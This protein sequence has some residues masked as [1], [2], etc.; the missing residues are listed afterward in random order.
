MAEINKN[1][2]RTLHATILS[3]CIL[4]TWP[5]FSFSPA[6][7]DLDFCSSSSCRLENFFF[8]A[9]RLR[10]SPNHCTQ[11]TPKKKAQPITITGKSA[12]RRSGGFRRCLQPRVPRVTPGF[13]AGFRFQ[14]SVWREKWKERLE[15]IKGGKLGKKCEHRSRSCRSDGNPCQKLFAPNGRLYYGRITSTVYYMGT[16]TTT[17]V[18]RAP[19]NL[20]VWTWGRIAITSVPERPVTLLQ[21]IRISIIIKYSLNRLLTE[22]NNKTKR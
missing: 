21:C 9:C 11:S 5:S 7:Q 12:M 20:P 22:K 17:T 2:Q 18:E 19:P 1:L 10:T 16:T 3:S 14:L 8:S 4:T 6:P 15:K 13:L